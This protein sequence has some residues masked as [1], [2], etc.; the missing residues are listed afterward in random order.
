MNILLSTYFSSL[1]RIRIIIIRYTYPTRIN[2]L[3]FYPSLFPKYMG[4][5]DL[6][7]CT[8]A[9]TW[10][11]SVAGFEESGVVRRHENQEDTPPFFDFFFGMCSLITSPI[12]FYKIENLIHCTFFGYSL[13]IARSHSTHSYQSLTVYILTSGRSFSKQT[14]HSI[15][16]AAVCQL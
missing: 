11:V 16:G 10:L 9:S 5:T 4:L 12:V 15:I 13:V 2:C 6:V 14:W 7:A 1:S 3:W 8:S